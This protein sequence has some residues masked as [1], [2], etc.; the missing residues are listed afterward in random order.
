[1]SANTLPGSLSPNKLLFDNEEDPEPVYKYYERPALTGGVW[2]LITRRFR[3]KFAILSILSFSF[4]WTFRSL[5]SDIT[6]AE[7]SSNV[8]VPQPS[9]VN[10]TNL[11]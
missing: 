1:M 2:P 11:V 6:E 8:Q 9:R 4:I 10:F 3:N 5:I 7:A